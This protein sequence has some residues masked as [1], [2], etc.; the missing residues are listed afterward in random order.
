MTDK[1]IFCEDLNH[2]GKSATLVQVTG[3]ACPCMT[4]RDSDNPSYSA[5]WH[6]LNPAAEDCNGTG[7]INRTT[8]NT[9]IKAYFYPP[10]ALPNRLIL[11]KEKIEVIGELQNDDLMLFGAVNASTGAYV[12]LSGLDELQDY[13]TIDSRKY[14]VRHYY[15]LQNSDVVGQLA[16]LRRKE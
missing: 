3:D 12:D 1:E 7:L 11:T 16:L 15:D 14:F 6:R 2:F 9:T 8:T 10:T 4:W 13:I 5:E